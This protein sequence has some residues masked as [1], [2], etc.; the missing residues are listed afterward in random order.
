[1][2][3]HSGE[4][5]EQPIDEVLDETKILDSLRRSGERIAVLNAQIEPLQTELAA[6]LLAVEKFYHLYQMQSEPIA[7]LAGSLIEANPQQST[8]KKDKR[9]KYN[10][11]KNLNIGVRRSY[12]WKEKKGLSPETAK[13]KVYASILKTAIKKG[14]HAATCACGGKTVDCTVPKNQITY[15]A[16]KH[17]LP[18]EV[19]A[20]IDEAHKKYSQLYKSRQAAA[21]VL[22]AEIETLPTLTATG[23]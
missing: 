20:K 4:A 5:V 18:A 1:M 19:I 21:E 16:V 13:K 9:S 7:L 22:V 14:V 11:I 6:E 17:D 2:I 10:P 23:V 8:K 15:V 3:E 12:E